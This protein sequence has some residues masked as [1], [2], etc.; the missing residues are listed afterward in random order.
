MSD[1]LTIVQNSTLGA[2]GFR[3]ENVA[4]GHN[5]SFAAKKHPAPRVLEEQSFHPDNLSISW[6]LYLTGLPLK[7][8]RGL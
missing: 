7:L 4:N 3:F 6:A 5:P 1:L 8:K 2:W